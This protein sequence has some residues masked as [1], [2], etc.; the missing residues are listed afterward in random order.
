MNLFNVFTAQ[1]IVASTLTSSLLAGCGFE[2]NNVGRLH[3]SAFE[4]VSPDENQQEGK[5]KQSTENPGDEDS[6][7]AND[8]SPDEETPNECPKA[9]PKA[10]K[11]ST[12][13]NPRQQLRIAPLKTVQ[14]TG[15]S[16]QDPDGHIESYH[17]ALTESPENSTARRT[18]RA[19]PMEVERNGRSHYPG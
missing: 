8:S 18:Q 10:S 9:I 3:H 6:P 1:I 11:T 4:G 19:P 14:L 16:S 13:S 17:W 7:P 2:E 15:Q 5:N 12:D